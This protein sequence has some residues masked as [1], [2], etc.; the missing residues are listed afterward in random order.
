MVVESEKI[1]AAEWFL[2]Y[3]PVATSHDR[4][5]RTLGLS[6]GEETNAFCDGFFA[7]ASQEE[8][9]RKR[10][11]VGTTDALDPEAGLLDFQRGC[12]SRAN[13]LALIIGS[14][15]EMIFVE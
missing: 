7:G 8:V 15:P 3:L 9:V 5:I 2:V 12:K 4:G 1:R 14:V 11:V 13:T 10:R 6:K